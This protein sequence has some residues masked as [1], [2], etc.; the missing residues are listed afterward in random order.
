[1]IW[2][3]WRQQRLQIFAVFGVVAVISAVLAYVRA[4]AVTLLPDKALVSD[5]YNMFLQYYVFL[6]LVFPVLFGMFFGAPLFAREIEHGTHVFGLTQSV[7]RTRWAVTKLAMAGSALTAATVILGLVGVWALEPINFV[8]Q[9]RMEN[10]VFEVQGVALVGYTLLA[11]AVGAV[12]GLVLRNTLAAMVVT[13]ILYTVV[14]MT[15]AHNVREHYATPSYFESEVQT[16]TG[17]AQPTDSWMVE[18]G[19]VDANGNHIRAS[20]CMSSTDVPGCTNVNQYAKSYA[21]VHL[22]TQFWRFQ[23]TELGLFILLSTGVL[24]V[25]ALAARRRLARRSW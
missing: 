11:F 5:T 24:G 7:S 4:D 3:A 18:S 22:P 9:G 19:L 17:Q 1:M 14:V 10:G 15:V 16:V 6:L 2:V 8:M 13:L 12:A 21:K 20:N 23:F 25:G